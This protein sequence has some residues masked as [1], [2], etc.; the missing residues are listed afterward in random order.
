[1]LD[2][3]LFWIIKRRY[4]DRTQVTDEEYYEL[5]KFKTPEDVVKFFKVLMTKQMF[6]HWEARDDSTQ[7]VMARGAANL[8]KVVLDAHRMVMIIENEEKDPI[9]KEARWKTFIKRFKIS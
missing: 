6:N 3:I 8:C 7:Q 1:M 5:L 9:K 4:N 2:K